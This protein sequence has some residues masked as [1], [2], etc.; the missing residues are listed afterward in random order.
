MNVRAEALPSGATPPDAVIA[1]LSEL[2]AALS[3]FS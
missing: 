3:S 1:T 2:P